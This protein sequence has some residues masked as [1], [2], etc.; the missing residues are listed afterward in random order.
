MTSQSNMF[1]DPFTGSEA[2]E[3]TTEVSEL[4]AVASQISVAVSGLPATA[5]S[6]ATEVSALSG[7]IGGFGSLE[8]ALAIL[9]ADRAR[10]FEQTVTLDANNEAVK[11]PCAILTGSVE[12]EQLSVELMSGTITNLTDLHFDLW[13]QTASTVLTKLTDTVL[14]G[15]AIGSIAA[16]IGPASE[17]LSVLDSS[18]GAL[19]EDTTKEVFSKFLLRGKEAAVNHI[20]LGYA[21]TEAP[22][23]GTVKVRVQYRPLSSNGAFSEYSPA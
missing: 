8:N 7:L 14:S 4:Q 6:L 3:L 9:S 10:I 17:A 1:Q 18:A 23:S 5:S 11:E 2:A 13:D 22:I 20:R 12:V 19:V 16:K 15:K 21:T